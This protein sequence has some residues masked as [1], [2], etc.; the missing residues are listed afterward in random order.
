MSELKNAL[1]MC[2]FKLPGYKIR[3]MVEDYDAKK[4]LT[5]PGKINFSEFEKV[6]K[7]ITS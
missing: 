7:I 5:Q 1:D 3:K 2:G 4:R 6:M